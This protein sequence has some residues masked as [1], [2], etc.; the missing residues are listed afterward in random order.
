LTGDKT[1][2][3]MKKEEEQKHEKKQYIRWKWKLEYLQNEAIVYTYYIYF[4]RNLL[5]GLFS[6]SSY[7]NYIP[8]I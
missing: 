3:E 7:T 4:Y 8:S 5:K 6:S 2:D 1:R